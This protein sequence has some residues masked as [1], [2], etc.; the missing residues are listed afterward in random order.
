MIISG[1]LQYSFMY[2]EE[3]SG[4]DDHMYSEIQFIIV[5]TA[6]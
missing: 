1:F 3:F 4:C 6:V 5:H 2:C